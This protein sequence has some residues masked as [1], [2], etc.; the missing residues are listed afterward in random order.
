MKENSNVEI[1]IFNILG[2]KMVELVNEKL[3]TG[4]HTFNFSAESYAKGIYFAKIKIDD[5]EQVIK[6][7]QK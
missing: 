1:N 7:I 5:K 6:L 3:N 2:K 4:N